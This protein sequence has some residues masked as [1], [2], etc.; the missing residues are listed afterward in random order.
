[1]KRY[2]MKIVERCFII[3]SW[4][5]IWYLRCA[6]MPKRFRHLVLGLLWPIIGY[7]SIGHGHEWLNYICAETGFMCD[8]SP[9]PRPELTAW[10][11]MYGTPICIMLALFML[12]KFR[13]RMMTVQ[14]R[15][16]RSHQ[17]SGRVATASRRCFW[18]L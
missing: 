5:F 9:P 18:W 11:Y 13:M 6:I 17:N 7:Q 10:R 4:P 12:N 15:L 16:K 3:F 1:M 8:G 14:R 2:L